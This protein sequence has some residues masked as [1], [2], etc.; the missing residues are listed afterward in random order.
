MKVAKCRRILLLS[1]FMFCNSKTPI[2]ACRS[3]FSHLIHIGLLRPYQIIYCVSWIVYHDLRVTRHFNNEIHTFL[4]VNVW[5]C[6]SF[7]RSL[8]KLLDN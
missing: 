7:V 6:C 3:V 2:K 8:E 4:Y 1:N 5:M